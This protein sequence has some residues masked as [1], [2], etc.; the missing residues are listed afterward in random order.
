MNPKQFTLFQKAGK[1]TSAVT[2]VLA[3]MAAQAVDV[4]PFTLNGFVKAEASRTSNICENCQTNLNED[5]HR[6]WADAITPGLPYGTQDGTTTLAQPYIGTKDFNLG[7]G[8]KVRGLW[9]QRWRDG[10]VDIPGIEYE[11]NVTFT[12]EDYGS[13]Q[14]G[15]FPTRGWSLADYPYGTQLGVADAWGAS[16][17]GYGLLTNAVRYG[18]PKQYVFGGDLHLEVTYDGGGKGYVHKPQFVEVMAQYV[19]G[20]WVIEGVIQQAKNGLPSAWSHGPF[21]G[22]T[23]NPADDKAAGPENKQSIVMLMARYKLDAKTVLFAGLRHNEWSGARGQWVGNDG[24]NDLWNTMFNIDPNN[25]ATTAYP[26][27]SEDFSL[28]FTRK[29]AEKVTL[30]FGLVHLG[31]ARTSNPEERGQSN[32]MTLGA[33]GLGYEI[34]PGWSAYGFVGAV[35]YGH[36][37]L[38]P[39]SMPSHASFS[40]VDSRVASHGKWAGLGMVYAF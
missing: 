34:Q 31:K 17:S 2:L 11:R 15:K 3:S 33:L 27:Q 35:N 28:G 23:V 12:Q 5:R 30:N 39:L 9:S 38:A 14:I 7:K 10:K 37:G 25:F 24:T 18:L 8:F 1:V 40:G 32:T 21:V 20:P 16:G 36:K 29:V 26:A 22:I 4:G 19:G 6:P 13:L